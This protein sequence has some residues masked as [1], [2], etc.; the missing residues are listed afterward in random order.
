MAAIA[1]N[2]PYQISNRGLEWNYR[3]VKVSSMIRLT[4][5]QLAI[6]AVSCLLFSWGEVAGQTHVFGNSSY[7]QT[8]ARF[9]RDECAAKVGTKAPEFTGLTWVN[10][11]PITLASLKG[12]TVLLHFWRGD[13]NCCHESVDAIRLLQRNYS[14]MGLV[15]IGIRK[16]DDS[17][18][19]NWGVNFPIA[20]DEKG[21]T[22]KRYWFD[23]TSDWIPG[24]YLIDKNGTVK[25]ACHQQ[26]LWRPIKA[27]CPD[28]TA[29]SAA[30]KNELNQ[31]QKKVSQASRVGL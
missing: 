5:C 27:A 3:Q 18:V 4:K 30:I 23:N 20:V 22:V 10:S 6:V 19:K 2:H 26:S 1:K 28:F 25:W 15:V 24:T 13:C 16:H 29:V 11:P 31:P 7:K 14:A 17:L 8:R 9:Q 12:K 21:N